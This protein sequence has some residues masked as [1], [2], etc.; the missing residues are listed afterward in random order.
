MSN[1][2]RLLILCG[3]WR[4]VERAVCHV[5]LFSHLDPSM[6]DR[7]A[8]NFKNFKKFLCF[9]LIRSVRNTLWTSAEILN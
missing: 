8:T 9:S 5:S 3:E 1:E 2:E 7:L 6:E 4:S